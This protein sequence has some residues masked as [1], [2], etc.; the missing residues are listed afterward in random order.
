M[1]KCDNKVLVEG[2]VGGWTNSWFRLTF[3]YRNAALDRA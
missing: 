2:D 1:K 3:L